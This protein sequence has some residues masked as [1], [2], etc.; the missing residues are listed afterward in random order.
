[1]KN[2]YKSQLKFYL[3]P[4]SLLLGLLFFI[5]TYADFFLRHNFFSGLQLSISFLFNSVPYISIILIPAL[6][7]K[8]RVALYDDF[9]PLPFYKQLLVRLLILLS[10]FTIYLLLLIPAVIITGLFYPFDFAVVIT[11]FLFLLLYGACVISLCLLIYQLFQNQIVAFVISSVLLAII[12]SAHNFSVY[13]SSSSFFAAIFKTLSFAW[14]FDA[15]GKAIFDSRDFIFFIVFTLL[16]L[17]LAFIASEKKKGRSFNK[18]QRFRNTSIIFILIMLFLNSGRYYFRLDFSKNKNFSL[19]KYSK[20]LLQNLPEPVI[21]TFYRSGTLSRLYPQIRDVTDFLDAYSSKN[22]NISF[23]LINPDGKAD[24][25]EQ[26]NNYGIQSQQID[27]SSGTSKGYTEV[28]SSI[29]LEYQGH[30]AVIPFILG[31]ETLEYDLDVRLKSLLTGKSPY[32]N[33][34]LG[35]GMNYS[36]DYS[37]IAPIFNSEGIL[38]NPLFPG[39]ADFTKRLEEAEGV[40]LVIGDSK[41]GIEDATAIENYILS[42]KGNAIFMLSPYSCDIAGDWRL[43]QNERTNLVE[44]LENWGLRFKEAIAT[45]IS[46]ARITMVSGDNNPA[47]NPYTQVLNYPMWIKLLKQENSKQGLT[48]FWPTPLE[49]ESQDSAG[50]YLVS[51]PQAGEFTINR[52]TYTEAGSLIETNPF[53][54]STIKAEGKKETKILAAQIKGKISGLYNY[55]SFDNARILVIPD[56]YFLNTL[57][58]NYSADPSQKGNDFSNF[59]FTVNQILKHSGEE[60]LAELQFKT[61]G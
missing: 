25:K 8:S 16:F 29:V 20:S 2:L 55:A 31:S 56:Q 28:F 39:T 21:I 54:I 49:I 26:L 22:K 48:L 41:I 1:M 23:K 53:V 12:N 11:S 32:V 34:I 19:S 6:A 40:L 3:T 24:I 60:E 42:G 45:D 4:K 59:D 10:I 38:I 51:T 9:I 17:Y 61:E 5:F 36:E 52:N 27:T 35:N 50:A 30:F 46:S 37:Y 13:I 7:S 44:M 14:H 33:I 47:E 43:L 57:M 15:S 18:S 58:N